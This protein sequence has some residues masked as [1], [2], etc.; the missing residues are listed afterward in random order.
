MCGYDGQVKHLVKDAILGQP[1]VI[2][3]RAVALL[4]SMT[5][6]PNTPAGVPER[7]AG[8]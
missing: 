1:D 8:R 2:D 7:K 5:I 3:T 4:W 6:G